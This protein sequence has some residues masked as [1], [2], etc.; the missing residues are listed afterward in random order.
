MEQSQAIINHE[1]YTGHQYIN[2]KLDFF[3]VSKTVA[4]I[5]FSNICEAVGKLKRINI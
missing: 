5:H 4:I 1:V 2:S 3:N